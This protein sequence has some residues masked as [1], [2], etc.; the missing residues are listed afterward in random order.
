MNNLLENTP[1]KHIEQMIW[2]FWQ[3]GRIVLVSAPE[4]MPAYR[5]SIGGI[6]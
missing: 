3:P 2:R 6:R 5:V 1:I 4:K